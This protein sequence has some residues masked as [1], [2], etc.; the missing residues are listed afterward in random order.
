VIDLKLMECAEKGLSLNNLLLI[1]AHCHLGVHSD[2]YIP[3]N[4][5]REQFDYYR[6][7]MDRVGVDYSCVSMLKALSGI[8]IESNYTLQD[9][10][11][12]D[13]RI[14]G[15]VV[16]SP[17]L[18]E[19]SMK[20][21]DKCIESS[22]RFIGLKIHPDWNRCA[23]DSDKYIPV[24]EYADSKRLPVLIHTWCSK[25]SDPSLLADIIKKYKNTKFLLGHSGG[26]EPAVSS[27][28]SLASQYDNVYLDLTGAFIYSNL[29]LEDYI[30]RISIK[31]MLFSSDMVFNNICWEVG[32]ILYANI[33]DN[34]K[35][36]ILGLNAKR[37]LGINFE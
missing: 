32:N 29:W 31:K 26:V 18:I 23:L 36:D 11:E 25:Y 14:L 6:K 2:F 4:S 35:K 33:E 19:K 15:W 27:A 16:Y 10:M 17:Y 1:D 20:I 22:R 30:K 13:G 37:V 7:T 3:F 28:I 9:Y 24:W 5:H 34:E 12:I 21:I 8:D